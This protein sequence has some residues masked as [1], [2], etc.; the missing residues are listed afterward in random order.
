[1]NLPK[2]VRRWAFYSFANHSYQAVYVAFLLPIF[3]STTLAKTGLPLSAWGLAA[4]AST[5]LGVSLAIVLGKYSDRHSKFEAYKWSMI[6]TA[7]GMFGMAFAAAYF[8]PFLYWSFIVTNAIFIWSLALYDSILPHVSD[9]ST[10]YEYGGFAWG[11]GYVGGI[12]SLLVALILQRIAGDYSFWVF[13]SVPVFYVL[14]SFYSIVGLREVSFHEPQKSHNGP[15]LS[16]KRKGILFLG[17]WL[18]S[19]CVT[20]IALFAATYLSGERHFSLIQVGIAFILIEAIGFPATWYGGRLTKKYS[21]LNLLGVTIVAWGVTLLSLAVFNIGWVGI[22]FF[23]VIMGLVYGNSQS[24]L[25]S[26]YATVI[27]RSE[28]GFQFGVYSFISEAA[29]IIGPVI[30]GYASDQL[31]S[32]KIPLV[33]LFVLM[34]IGYGLVWAVMRNIKPSRQSI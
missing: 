25:R 21:S 26:Q 27:D 16:R 9:S 15:I 29:V 31:H 1:M 2:S 13:L 4:G 17:Y 32:Q 34:A 6:L 7:V 24:Y 19:E 33:G 5:L 22:A 20:V 18:I 10:V 28:S 8:Q 30:Y 14:F 3:F 23:V 11:F 12:A